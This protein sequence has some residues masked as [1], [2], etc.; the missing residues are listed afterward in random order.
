MIHNRKTRLIRTRFQV[1]PDEWDGNEWKTF[2]R[3]TT[4]GYK[5]IL[6]FVAVTARKL[7]INIEEAMAC[8]ILNTI[9]VFNAP[10]P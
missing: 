9:A 5:R 2:D 7:R 8:P 4:I 6:R 10:E 1:Y 3:Q